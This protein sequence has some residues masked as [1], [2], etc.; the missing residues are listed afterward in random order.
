[1]GNVFGINKGNKPAKQPLTQQQQ[2]EI[3][4]AKAAYNQQ[5]MQ[6]VTNLQ[7]NLNIKSGKP[8]NNMPANKFPTKK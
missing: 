3:N 8:N 5:K 6:G 1:M 2:K 4:Q 7:N